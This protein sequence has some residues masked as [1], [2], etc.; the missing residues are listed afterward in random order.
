MTDHRLRRI[1]GMRRTLLSLLCVA[2]AVCA[3]TLGAYGAD[4]PGVPYNIMLTLTPNP[5]TSMAFTWHTDTSVS[6]GILELTGNGQSKQFT[7]ASTYIEN[8]TRRCFKVT[9]TG[10]TP[11]TLYHY[12]VG[13]GDTYSPTYSF[14]T[15]P[16]DGE[17]FSFLYVTDSQGITRAHYDAWR[18]CIAAAIKRRPELRFIVH[19]GDMTDDGGSR[20]QWDMFSD[21]QA[22][23][24]LPMLPV[25]GNHDAYN[26]GVDLY[27][28]VFNV[29]ELESAPDPECMAVTYGDLRIAMLNSEAGA[30]NL[31]KQANWLEPIMGNNTVWRM[32]AIHRGPYGATDRST[33]V[34]N[35]LKLELD[36][37][38]LDAV[39]QGHDHVYMRSK[40]IKDGVIVSGGTY[41][42]IGN[43]SAVKQYGTETKWW[44]EF[45]KQPGASYTIVDVSPTELRFL[46]YTVAGDLVDDF[47]IKKSASKAKQKPQG[48]VN[49]DNVSFY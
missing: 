17:S 1:I 45:V 38:R 30:E 25:V 35:A 31:V 49:I 23:R 9:A 12:R 26:G 22:L 40:P 21:V 39:L 28:S 32:A 34:E 11:G 19:C 48:T 14:Y 27:R 36:K 44:H 37:L 15:A 8:D 20:Q 33:D 16:K 6:K 7:A 24:Y 29:T 46:T 5:S 42:F 3:L 4:K 18:D 43:Y 2:I 13:Y 10:L 41:Y 47:T